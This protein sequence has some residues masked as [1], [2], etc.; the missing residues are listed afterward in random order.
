VQVAQALEGLAGTSLGIR[1]DAVATKRLIEPICNLF[2][3]LTAAAVA[4]AVPSL[5]L[6]QAGRQV[7]SAHTLHT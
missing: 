7:R 5:P 6:G 2:L 4:Q 1:P 3:P